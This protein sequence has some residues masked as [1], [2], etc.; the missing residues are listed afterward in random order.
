MAYTASSIRKAYTHSKATLV[1]DLVRAGVAASSSWSID[2]LVSVWLAKYGEIETPRA[3]YECPECGS[4]VAL[5]NGNVATHAGR[6]GET[7]P[8]SA[9]P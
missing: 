7:C 3:D 9:R 1:R 5:E 8:K 4:G 6:G 2:E